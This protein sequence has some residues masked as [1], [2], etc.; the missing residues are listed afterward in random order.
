MSKLRAKNRAGR[1]QLRPRRR[2]LGVESLE[3]R[4]VLSAFVVNSDDDTDDGSCDDSH[5]SLREAIEAA[6]ASTGADLI[7]FDIPAAEVPTIRP[8]S[9]LPT[10]TDPVTIDGTT[11][12]AGMVELDGTNAGTNTDGIVISSGG[13]T[14]RGLVINRFDGTGVHIASGGE[15]VLEANRI[16]TDTTGTIAMGNDRS[17]VLI[18]SGSSS[19]RIGTDGDDVADEGERNIISGNGG[20]GVRI[21]G[22]GSQNYYFTDFSQEAPAEFSGVTTTESVQGYAGLG[23]GTNVF[24]DS[25][26]RNTTAVTNAGGTMSQHTVLTLSALPTHTAINLNF[27]FAAIDSWDTGQSA[28]PDFFNVAVDG[29]TIF[30]ENFANGVPPNP[31]SQGYDAPNGVQ[32]TNR[33][34]TNLG[35][36]TSFD[37]AWNL[38]LDPVL[39]D[40]PHTASTLTIEWFADGC[41]WQGGFDESWAI[42]NVEVIVKSAA[43]SNNVVAGNFIGTDVTGTAALGNTGCGV[44]ISNGASNNL[45]GTDGDGVADE[46]ERNILSGSQISS[47]GFG[48]GVTITGRGTDRNRVAGNF[49]G[50]DA[51]GTQAVPNQVAGV[52]IGGGAQMNLIGTNSDG[53]ADAA[54]RNV[55]SGNLTQGVFL[56]DQ[57][58]DQNLVAGNFIGTDVTGTTALGNGNFGVVIF[59]GPQRNRIGVTGP[60]AAG[61]NII[62]ANTRP[63]VS[64]QGAGAEHNMV[65]GN[66]IGTDVTGERPL[67]NAQSGIFLFT[68]ARFNVI[69]TDGDGTADLIERNVISANG[70]N[71]VQVTGTGTS[72]NIVAGN[73]IGT[74]AVGQVALGNE[75]PGVVIAEGAQSNRIGTNGDGVSDAAERNLISGNSSAGVFIGNAG[76]DQN[77]VAG[78]YIGTDASGT[79]ALGNLNWG[80]LIEQGAQQNVIGTNGDG[81][82][83]AAE[84]NLISGNLGVGVEI[85]GVDTDLN[86]VSGNFVGIVALGV[87]ALGNTQSGVVISGGAGQNRIGT[88]GD[89]LAD[90]AE[91]NVISG[92]L[93][94][95]IGLVG[96]QAD[97]NIV[98]GNLI[99]ISAT[100]VA[101]IPN[102]NYGVSI[103]DGAQ[104]NRIG[105]NGDGF[106]DTAER[107]IISGNGLSG[108]SLSGS[109]TMSNDVAGNFIG[110]NAA[111]TGALGNQNY[112]VVLAGGAWS[113]QIGMD[114]FGLNPESERNVISG[115]RWSGLAFLDSNTRFNFAY[116]NSIGSDL[117]GTADLGNELDGVFVSDAEGTIG[118]PP[119]F[120]QADL[121]NTIA[122]NRRN[123]ILVQS[124]NGTSIFSNSIFS[125]G[126]LGIDLGADARVT[127][128]DPLDRDSGANDLQNFP[129]LTLVTVKRGVATVRGT[130]NSLPRTKFTIQF[131]GSMA[132]DPSGF[133]EGET[134]L[135]EQTFTTKKKGVASF[136]AR[137]HGAL[138]PGEFVTAT[139]T[140]IP[141]FTNMVPGSTSEFSAAFRVPAPRSATAALVIERASPHLA[142]A[143]DTGSDAAAATRSLFTNGHTPPRAAAPLNRDSLSASA[144]LAS[145][146]PRSR[147]ESQI[148][149]RLVDEIFDSNWP[150][151]GT[152]IV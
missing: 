49:I 150:S 51:T 2:Q 101:A 138:A 13:S 12:S 131:Y 123:G 37:S 130:L 116:G 86:A 82:G 87:A 112:G 132:M 26:L 38:G 31:D 88:N 125:N 96:G 9:G 135:G 110:T 68:G 18:D 34:F 53:G 27:L 100:G 42:D 92:N 52:F 136:S 113:N 115:N 23:T 72:E 63:G 29:T 65:S 55:I 114:P 129:V 94:S 81:A 39:D 151:L 90:A 77:V 15:N 41:C 58:T 140:P 126:A 111:G 5:C 108:V 54:E 1:G 4:L 57:G 148:E 19:N 33:P 134:F 145:A 36:D 104:N 119:G 120:F 56:R 73:F 78:N 67:G 25:F 80:V 64:I 128:N 143:L 8:G 83:D 137:L 133:G 44:T 105:T 127:P 117:A 16:G 103:Q 106:G 109:N 66:Y 48:C 102:A 75:F 84:R 79:A 28:G 118:Y 40:I 69:G 107:N 121:G 144:R 14:V 32:L 124:G 22:V 89:G 122:F 10:I 30:R 85:H 61:R 59:L 50:T 95:G 76:S 45:I 149:H 70:G 62:S 35:F 46:A 3:Q 74:D 60:D 47:D 98:A 17:G 43:T 11:Q 152:N 147:V 7:R 91:R 21:V 146:S 20:D 6:N 97:F 71:G 99:G 141:T 142:L 93:G 24:G 139:A